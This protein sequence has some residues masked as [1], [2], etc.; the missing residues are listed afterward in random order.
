M[1]RRTFIQNI[2]L[3]MI[4]TGL[5]PTISAANFIPS[6][7]AGTIVPL[8]EPMTQIRHG[9]LNLPI[10]FQDHSRM[11]FDWLQQV[12]RNI[13]FG[14]GFQRNVDAD[15]EIVS[16]LLKDQEEIEAVQ[17]QLEE[18]VVRIMIDED[19]YEVAD[20]ENFQEIPTKALNVKLIIGNLE[21]DKDYQYSFG[22]R[23]PVF[24]QPLSGKLTCNTQVLG[25]QTGL[26]LPNVEDLIFKVETKSQVVLLSKELPNNK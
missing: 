20:Q 9:A 26:A 19:F 24:I 10:S 8:A 13:F 2:G 21:P 16:V 18:E 25:P 6:A 12:Q 23:S 14:N 4:A 7:A 17:I 3:G 22:K 11:P 1:Q 15:L 5:L